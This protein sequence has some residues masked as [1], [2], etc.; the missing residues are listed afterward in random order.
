MVGESK[1]K[2]RTL[3]GVFRD[4]LSAFWRE[5]Y[6]ECTLGEQEKVPAL[7]HD[8]QMEEWQAVGQILVKEF[9]QAKYFPAQ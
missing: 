2:V 3:V 5:F 1:N 6:E 9:M 4:V 8:F 7:R